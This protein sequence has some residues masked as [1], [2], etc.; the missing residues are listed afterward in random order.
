MEKIMPVVA[1]ALTA[2]FGMGGGRIGYLIA[3]RLGL[4]NV[5][6][7]APMA[8]GMAG[9]FISVRLF[10]FLYKGLLQAYQESR[11]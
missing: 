11:G 5:V 1:Y 4:Q 10:M 9:G 2:G 6:S 7:F 3:L 8:A